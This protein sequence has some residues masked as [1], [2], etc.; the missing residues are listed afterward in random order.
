MADLAAWRIE[1]CY[2]AFRLHC[3]ETHGLFADDTQSLMQLDLEH[4]VLTFSQHYCRFTRRINLQVH[5]P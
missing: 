2:A 4:W 3:I 5:P 1:K